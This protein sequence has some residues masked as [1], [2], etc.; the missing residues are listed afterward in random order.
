MRA[1]THLGQLV[2]AAARR[3]S[4]VDLMETVVVDLIEAILQREHGHE[5]VAPLDL[6]GHIRAASLAGHSCQEQRKTTLIKE[7]RLQYLTD[8]K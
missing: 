8:L 1:C 5:A 2:R 6:T 7:A 4:L 3:V